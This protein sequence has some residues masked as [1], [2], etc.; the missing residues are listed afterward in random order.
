MDRAE[1]LKLLQESAAEIQ[2][3]QDEL[4]QIR[5]QEAELQ[6]QRVAKLGKLK[7]ARDTRHRRMTA[8]IDDSVPKAQVARAS[9]MDRTNLYK[10][11]SD[12][13]LS[14]DDDEAS[15]TSE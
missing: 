2:R 3:L 4:Q 7:K 5:D 6:E 12:Y 9:D 13:K 8:A 10:L 1:H 14:D 11:L 15:T